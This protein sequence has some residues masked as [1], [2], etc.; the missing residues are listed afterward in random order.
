MNLFYSSNLSSSDVFLT[1][2]TLFWATGA[3]ALLRAPIF[4]FTHLVA[5][6]PGSPDLALTLIQKYKVTH[7]MLHPSLIAQILFMEK[8]ADQSMV[9]LKVIN[10]GGAFLPDDVRRRFKSHL[11]K[12]CLISMGYGCTEKPFIS[13]DA[14][15]EN[16]RSVGKLL[17]NVVV[18][19][20]DDNDDQVGVGLEGEICVKDL[21]PWS[22]YYGDDHSSREAYDGTWYKTGDI[23]RFDDKGFLYIVDR[24][25]EILKSKGY[26][27]S[28][29]EI[30]GLILQI[31][32]V[33]AAC[34]VGIP[35]VVQYNI[36]A[37]VVIKS[38]DS[39]LTADD[40]RNFVSQKTPHYKHLEGGVYFVDYL[41]RTATG[42]VLRREVAKL[43]IDRYLI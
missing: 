42:K 7:T 26:Q 5:S 31:N 24:K 4:G 18:K 28:P 6:K 39:I 17:P 25:K 27:V 16:Y 1:F 15:E 23:G 12:G 37:A 30:E 10:T 29:S 20:L 34:V 41:P 21:C 2:S 32:D 36:L 13:C 35:D 38:C 9:S 22:G 8:S 43:A 19:L 40:I 33:V 11:S 14:L 3:T